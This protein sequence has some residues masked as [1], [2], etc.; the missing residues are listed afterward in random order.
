MSAAHG[1]FGSERVPLGGGAAIF[2]RLAASSAFSDLDLQL[3]GAGPQED[4]EGRYLRILHQEET[5]STLSMLEYARF[6][7]RFGEATTDRVLALRPDILLCHDISEGPDVARLAAAGVKVVTVFHVDVVDIFGRL[8]LGG[9]VDPVSLTSGYRRCRRLPWPAVLRLVFEKQQQVADHG[10]LSIVPSRG[11]GEL[12]QRC[13]PKGRAPILTLGWGV[14]EDRFPPPSVE[15]KSHELKVRHSIPT[16]HRVL[17]TLSRLSPEKA[18]HRLLQAI[19][20]A[21]SS[22]RMPDDVTV[23]IAG[24]AAFMEGK[25]HAHKLRKLA[26][27]IETRVI[28]PGHV[29]GLEKAAW[30]RMADLF[31]VNSLHESYGLTTLEAMQQCCPVI[32]VKSFGTADTVTDDVG[33]LVPPGP[34][35]ERRLWGTL[36]KYLKDEAKD[37]LETMGLN[38]QKKA[39]LSTFEYTAETIRSSLEALVQGAPLPRS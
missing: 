38:A 24:E 4:S 39:A 21:E 6:C 13:Y 34:E 26:A 19:E 1:G 7:R 10:A 3:L 18:Q 35:I 37:Q 30:Y 20:F 16:H 9:L 27:R 11:A 23:V 25:R 28:F 5:P 22:G 29:G 12:L 33:R 8:Y 17:L 31:V 32:A 2:E 14:P 36:E 15:R